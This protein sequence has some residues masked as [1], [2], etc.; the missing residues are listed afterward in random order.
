MFYINLLAPLR[1][2]PVHN[3][4]LFAKI[5]LIIAVLQNAK[6]KFRTEKNYL[7]LRSTARNTFT[8]VA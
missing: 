8:R 2:M 4:I 1:A 3:L 7:I 6:H 5:L